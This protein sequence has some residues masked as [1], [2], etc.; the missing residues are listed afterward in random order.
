[1]KLSKRSVVL[2]SLMTAVLLTSLYLLNFSLYTSISYEPA[3]AQPTPIT[4][5]TTS[6]PAPP[7]IDPTLPKACQ[8][9]QQRSHHPGTHFLNHKGVLPFPETTLLKTQATIPSRISFLHYNEHFKNPRYLCGMESA[10]RQNPNHTVFIYA[11][12][13]SD[14]VESTRSWQ[15]LLGS[16][17]VSK[18]RIVPIEWNQM[19]AMTPLQPW[20]DAEIYRKSTWPDQNLGNAFRLAMLWKTGGVYLD[21]DIISLNPVG[22][23]GR[24]VAMQTG[25]KIMNNAFFSFGKE[26]LFVWEMMEEFVAG[27]NGTVWGRNG[28]RMVER[29][30]NKNCKPKTLNGKKQPVGKE[31]S[32][33]ISPPARLFPISYAS[34]KKITKPWKQSCGILKSLAKDSIGMHWWNKGIKAQEMTTGSVFEAVMIH[35]CPAT[36]AAFTPAGLGFFDASMAQKGKSNM[37]MG[38]EASDGF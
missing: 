36:V 6:L 13:V 18:L 35:Y 37:W 31:C 38:W 20:F 32:F 24:G 29:T 19:F 5:T 25:P 1:M 27:F 14:F 30:Y 10:A 2:P 22:A 11:K 28:P 26:D 23:V 8:Y 16:Q 21:S 3:P 9:F 7:S 17:V 15:D 34:R 4:T 12:N 33:G